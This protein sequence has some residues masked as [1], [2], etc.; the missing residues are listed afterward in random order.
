MTRAPLDIRIHDASIGIWQDNAQDASFRSEVYGVLI[1]Q[2]RDRGWSI[3]R[4]PGI[5]YRD[6]CLSPS[7]RLGARGTLRC[8]IEISGRVVKV[9]FWSVTAPQVNQNG[10]RY[11][12]DRKAR[13]H[14][15]EQLRVVLEFRRIVTWLE[16]IA[17]VKVS[18]SET[19]DMSPMER[20]E[21]R[22]AESRHKDKV[23]GRPT[24]SS[25]SQRKS[26]DGSLLEHGQ[27]VWIPDHKGRLVRGVAYY[28]INNMWWVVAGG[29][30]YNEG[31]HSLLTATPADIR[32]KRNQRARRRRI[33]EELA[34]AIRR[35]NFQRAE[36]LKRILFGGDATFMIWARDHNAYYRAQYAGY[37]TDVISAGKYTRAEAEAECRRVPHELS[38]VDQDGRH[39]RFDKVAA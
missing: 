27:T 30:L 23:L 34:L 9:E 33:E 32:A 39:T 2:M 37:T 6:K 21:K 25:E 1:R 12:F 3:K 14:H 20:I 29:Q 4:D 22:Y 31:C 5:H 8:A 28:N 17:P 13:M 38:I 10:R 36:T 16:T 18:R 15:I 24:W 35:M 26:Q 19:R 11:D 7:Y